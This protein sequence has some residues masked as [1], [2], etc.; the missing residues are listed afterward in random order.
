MSGY[1]IDCRHDLVDNI[2]GEVDRVNNWGNYIIIKSDLGFFIEI[3]HIMQYSL[4]VKVGD[5]VKVNEIVAKC[6][7]SGYS[8]EPHI[9]IQVQDLGVIGAFTREFCFTE[10]Y[11][12]N[13][14]IF[15][16]LPK[17]DETIS[18]VIIDKSISSR[19]VFILDDIF[20]YA[21]FKDNKR[22]D[23][24]EFVVKMNQTSEFYFE[25]KDKNQLY[26]YNDATQFYFYNYIGGDSHLKWLFILLPRI[27]Y[28]NKNGIEYQ[29]YLPVNLVKDRL[30]VITTLLIST[31]KKNYYK[32]IKRYKYYQRWTDL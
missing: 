31:I 22:I 9:H 19:L 21:V 6:G 26:F 4:S 32:T 28:I 5:Y 8:P 29:D 1:V 3:S 12:G 13:E 30:G 23:E 10:Y 15:N 27:P 24:I 16:S 11:K 20:K 25:D 17:K 18:S 14:L 7:N 2:I